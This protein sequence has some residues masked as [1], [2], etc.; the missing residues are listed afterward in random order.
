MRAILRGPGFERAGSPATV[1][2][3]WLGGQ[4]HL[5]SRPT[6]L[7]TARAG[8]DRTAVAP[9]RQDGHL[10]PHV[11]NPPFHRPDASDT[12]F[13]TVAI[14]PEQ[15]ANANGRLTQARIALAVARAQPL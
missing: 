5:Q 13:P 4:T 8:T 1:S 10:C 9:V 3:A 15:R 6:R 2:A 14:T 12:I 11:R 7:P